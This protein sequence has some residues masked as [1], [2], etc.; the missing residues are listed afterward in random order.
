MPIFGQLRNCMELAIVAALIVKEDLPAKAGN[1][2]PV[3]M[4]ARTR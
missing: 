1:S 3:L 4:D 2:L